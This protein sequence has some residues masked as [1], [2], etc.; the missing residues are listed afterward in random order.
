[1]IGEIKIRS[2]RLRAYLEGEFL[3]RESIVVRR[4]PFANDGVECAPEHTLTED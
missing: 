3:V 2:V 1:M 4:E